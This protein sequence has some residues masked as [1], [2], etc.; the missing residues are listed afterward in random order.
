MPQLPTTRPRHAPRPSTRAAPS[1]T[2]RNGDAGSRYRVLRPRSHGSPSPWRRCRSGHREAASRPPGAPRRSRRRSR[3]SRRPPPAGSCLVHR[4]VPRAPS[5]HRSRRRSDGPAPTRSGFATIK[6]RRPATTSVSTAS[7][8]A[9]R[10][11]RHPPFPARASPRSA[12]LVSRAS[13]DVAAAEPAHSNTIRHHCDSAASGSCPGRRCCWD[14]QARR[15]TGLRCTRRAKPGA[16]GLRCTRSA[17]PGA[18]GRM[19]AMGPM[20]IHGIRN[21]AVGFQFAPHDAGPVIA[22]AAPG[23]LAMATP[24]ARCT[25]AALRGSK[26]I[27]SIPVQSVQMTALRAK[28]APVA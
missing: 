28:R 3:T 19:G 14:E 6:P 12:R 16:M 25:P 2:A 1:S 11:R 18:M 20:G 9:L 26:S 23:A 21:D 8:S 10:A 27:R 7:T 17:T 24:R 13:R 5:P 22:P 15:A 4:A